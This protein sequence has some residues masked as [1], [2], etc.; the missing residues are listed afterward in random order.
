MPDLGSEE[1]ALTG[2][3]FVHFI[4]GVLAALVGI[5][6]LF[7]L[8]LQIL[9]EAWENSKLGLNFFNS[10]DPVLQKATGLTWE[11][12]KGD[13]LPNSCCDVA[14]GSLGWALGYGIRLKWQSRK[15]TT[16]T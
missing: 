15:K 7:W 3:T 14:A 10:L 8:L 9:F 1:D 4:A 16:T 11:P 2:F 12:Y 13:S 6:F 5:S